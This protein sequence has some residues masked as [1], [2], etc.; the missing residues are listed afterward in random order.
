MDSRLDTLSLPV[1]KPSTHVPT[2]A[3][4]GGQSDAPYRVAFLMHHYFEWIGTFESGAFR[5]ISSPISLTSRRGF[6]D[7]IPITSTR[8]KRE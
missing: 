3:D 5:A 2:D 8:N 7:G 4:L 6:T 1:L